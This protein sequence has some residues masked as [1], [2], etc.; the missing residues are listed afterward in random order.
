MAGRI[1]KH[2][3]V[4]E[5]GPG[6]LPSHKIG[7]MDLILAYH[8]ILAEPSDYLY[9][10]NSLQ[11]SEHLLLFGGG[12]ANHAS[13]FAA[14]IL[15]F[16]DGHRSN[17]ESAFPLLERF[18]QKAIFFVLAGCVGRNREYLSWQQAREIATA[19]HQV[20]SH[21]W[22]HRLLTNCNQRELRYE[23]EH[24][25]H[26]MEDRLG[27]EVTSI[28]VPGGRWNADVAEECAHAGYKTLF[29]SNPWTPVR[30][31]FGVRVR[32]RLMVTARMGAQDLQKRLQMSELQ[33][34]MCRFKYGAKESLR[35]AL[36]DRLYHRIW[37]RLANYD[38]QDGMEIQF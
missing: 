32:G 35:A 23:L 13:G 2:D 25:K 33:R 37:C 22:S 18:G 27:A 29:H 34:V 30:N 24:S 6:K 4:V 15:T 12:T 26:E 17:I 7:E 14:P 36:G 1:A 10:V 3:A 9:H 11:F 19:G 28:S 21:G 16:D 5:H 20:Q 8:D 31:L 38:P